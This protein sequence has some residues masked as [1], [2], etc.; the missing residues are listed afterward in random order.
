MPTKKQINALLEIIREAQYREDSKAR[1]K[2]KAADKNGI[3]VPLR[4]GVQKLPNGN[5]MV[6][7]G[8]VAVI[9]DEEIP[10]LP[11]HE[12]FESD[13]MILRLFQSEYDGYYFLV[14]NPFS[15]DIQASKIRGLLRDN[16]E[17][18]PDMISSGVKN[19]TIDLYAVDER[20]NE[21]KGRYKSVNVRRAVEALGGTP[22]LYIG[23]HDFRKGRQ[24]YPYLMV[25]PDGMWKLDEG[26]HALV[27]PIRTE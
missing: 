3:A 23:F 4:C 10:E 21:F 24:P 5:F 2:N 13:D 14:Q 11:R 18:R 19:K 7:D 22:R 16:S 20:Q 8:Y 9:F 15:G 17:G 27:M 26:F 1:M 12:R 25:E 6:T